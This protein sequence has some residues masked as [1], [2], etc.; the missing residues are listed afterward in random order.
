MK[1][2]I[3]KIISTFFIAF[4]VA[5]TFFL[6]RVPLIEGKHL[7]DP[8]IDTQFAKNYSPEKFATITV[9]MSITEVIVIVGEPLYKE[10]S[11]TDTLLTNYCYTNDGKLLHSTSFQSLNSYND[12]A[13]YRST[14][15]IDRTNRV[16][17]ID[18]GWS[19]D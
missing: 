17:S 16:I 11:Y 9:G 5:I 7:L 10:H 3:L 13:W 18:K 2:S 15:Q 4:L 6:G 1:I 19:Y 14:L 8:Y 12:F